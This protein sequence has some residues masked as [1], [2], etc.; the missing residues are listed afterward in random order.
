MSRTRTFIAIDP[1]KEEK[2]TAF[3]KLSAKDQAF[4]VQT[5]ESLVTGRQ[6]ARALT[7]R[8]PTSAS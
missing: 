3:W 1:G 5:T 8:R 4:V 2:L 7:R 6:A